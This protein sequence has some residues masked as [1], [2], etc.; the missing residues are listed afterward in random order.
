MKK[1]I[2]YPFYLFIFWI[3]LFNIFRIFFFFIDTTK[4]SASLDGFYHGI[5]IDVATASYLIFPC[6]FIWIISLYFNNSSKS[7]R[8]FFLPLNISLFIVVCIIETV[9]I[10]LFKEWGTTFNLRAFEYLL[11][12]KEVWH[13]IS[14]FLTFTL[15][16][17]FI[18]LIF[19]GVVVLN[20]IHSIGTTRVTNRWVITFI[21]LISLIITMIGT[22]GGMGK[23]PINTSSCFYSNNQSNNYL[24]V[25]KS[26]YFINSLM[27]KKKLNIANEN[28]SHE[29]LNKLYYKLYSNKSKNKGIDILDSRR[30]NIVLIILEG[31]PADVFKPLGGLKNVTPSFTNLC[32]EGILFSNIYSSGF[33]TDQGILSILSG[34]PALPYFNILNDIEITN[35]FPSIIKTLKKNGYETSFIFGGSLDFSNL[36]NYFL[37][38]KTDKII[39]EDNFLTKERTISLGVP[40]NILFNRVQKEVAKQKEPFFSCILTQS[41]HRPFD[42]KTK[43]KFSGEGMPELFESSVYF[44]DSCIG[45]FIQNCK[46]ERWYKNTIFIITSDHGSLY[47]GN[48]DFNDHRRFQVPLLIYGP[49]IKEQ[50]KGNMIVNIGNHY[51]FPSTLLSILNIPDDEFIFSKNL[52]TNNDYFHAYWI[53]EHTLGWITDTQSIVINNE[54]RE[55]YF[56]KVKNMDNSMYK[57]NAMDFYKLVDDYVLGENKLNLSKTKKL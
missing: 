20:L 53:T 57:S 48:R 3:V 32:I 28:I 21:S 9:S 31:C 14:D 40:D 46:N 24:A 51:D 42:L 22:R 34:V 7:Y 37:N 56:E 38:N 39:G 1:N 26:F 54:T 2:L 52:L 4:S 17:S 8:R 25:N 19:I 41:S 33:R 44:T 45:S 11:S 50:Y 43:H 5:R 36:N 27:K 18:I 47:L 29:E 35:R 16:F 23:F 49:P 15:F 13:T 12:I 10:P 55:L 6:L 30:P